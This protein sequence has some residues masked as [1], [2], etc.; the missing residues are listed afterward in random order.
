MAYNATSGSRT[1]FLQDS[2]SWCTIIESSAEAAFVIDIATAINATTTAIRLAILTYHPEAYADLADIPGTRIH[3]IAQFSSDTVELVTDSRSCPTHTVNTDP[4]SL[5]LCENGAT[6]LYNAP[7]LEQML[8]SS[9]TDDSLTVSRPPWLST[10]P[11]AQ[12]DTHTTQRHRREPNI[13]W[14]SRRYKRAKTVDFSYTS[15]AA[16][17]LAA[18]GKG[19]TFVRSHLVRCG[20]HHDSITSEKVVKAKSIYFETSLAAF[21]RLNH[22]KRRKIHEGV[23]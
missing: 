15:D 22:T 13:G 14:A 16:V 23:D 8:A 6:Q 5:I 3:T 18:L 9:A 7:G 12:F 10:V 1:T 21:L 11:A 17:N 20:Y 2:Y 19:K 4:L